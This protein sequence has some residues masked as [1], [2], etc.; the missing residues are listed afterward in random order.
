MSG[1]AKRQET[2]AV[3]PV[4]EG[5]LRGR[6]RRIRVQGH[7]LERVHAQFSA[8]IIRHAEFDLALAGG[9]LPGEC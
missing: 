3:W 6:P 5:T 4:V 9:R 2:D 1:N 8:A 7:E